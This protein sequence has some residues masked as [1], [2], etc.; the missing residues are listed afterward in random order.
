M[1]SCFVV[2]HR[3]KRL[4]TE[5][6]SIQIIPPAMT[7]LQSIIHSI[8]DIQNIENTQL[9]NQST[10]QDD[11]SC[12]NLGVVMILYRYFFIW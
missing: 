5:I 11:L 12:I 1:H 4:G 8:Q 3:L 10:T 6:S 2:K 9:A 7:T